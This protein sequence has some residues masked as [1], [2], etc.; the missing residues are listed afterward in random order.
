MVGMVRGVR[1][2]VVRT[3]LVGAFA[4]VVAGCGQSSAATPTGGGP[5]P[6]AP[7]PVTASTGAPATAAASGEPAPA[8][9]FAPLWPFADAQGAAA[10]QREHRAGG[11][12]PW[13]LDP[14]ATALGFARALG[15]SGLDRVTSTEVQGD[16]AWVGVGYAAPGEAPA[17]AGVVHLARLGS[18]DDAPWEAVGTRDSTLTLDTPAYRAAVRSPVAVGGEITGVDESMHVQV[19]AAGDARLL[20]ESCCPPAGGER[21]R[22]TSTVQAQGSGL[23]TVVVSTGGHVADVELFAVTAVRLG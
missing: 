2:R 15:L 22:W 14:G 7:P 3:V 6:A 4:L 20:G 1:V 21:Q 16:Q 18:G 8:F 19:R 11:Q 12:E 10:W 9:A 13:H 17:T 23:A 5:P